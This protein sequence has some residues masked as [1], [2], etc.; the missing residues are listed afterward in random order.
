LN[1]LANWSVGVETGR[2]HIVKTCTSHFDNGSKLIS[3]LYYRPFLI[4]LTIG[5]TALVLPILRFPE[6][7]Y[8]PGRS[9]FPSPVLT[10]VFFTAKP[11]HITPG[12]NGDTHI[13]PSILWFA[14]V[15]SPID[16]YFVLGPEPQVSV[17]NVQASRGPSLSKVLPC[18]KYDLPILRKALPFPLRYYNLMRHPK[19]SRFLQSFPIKSC[20]CRLLSSRLEVGPSRRYL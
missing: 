5:V 3:K 14:L 11:S 4:L 10:L 2:A 18:L 17:L 16:R 9:D 12:L 20:L 1:S 19:S 15:V 6:P 8:N 13:R 7:P